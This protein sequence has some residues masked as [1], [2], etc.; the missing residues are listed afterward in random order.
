MPKPLPI[1]LAA[2]ATIMICGSMPAQSGVAR[3]FAIEVAQVPSNPPVSTGRTINLT[4]EDRHT[5]REIV[6]K[7][8]KIEKAPDN[9][10]V[11]ISSAVPPGVNLQPVPNDVT[12]KVPQLRNNTFFVKGDE[13]VIVE[14]KDNTVADIVKETESRPRAPQ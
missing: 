3:A 11:S 4:E 14:P 5:I 9:I 13:V 1:A 8:S 6:L 7:D 2:A 10:E 12:R